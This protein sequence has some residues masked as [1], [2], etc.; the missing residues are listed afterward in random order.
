MRVVHRERLCSKAYGASVSGTHT[1]IIVALPREAAALVS[2]WQAHKQHHH[3]GIYMWTRA[4]AIVVAAGMGAARAAFAV[5]AALAHGAVSSLISA[6]LAGA[7]DPAIAVGSVIEAT[8]VIDARSGERHTTASC[9]PQPVRLVTG[10]GIAGIREKARLF[11]SYDAAACDMEAATVARLAGAHQ[12]PFR[13]IKAVSDNFDFELG[14]MERFTTRHGHFHT[15]RFALHTAVRPH[16]WAKTMKL[17][18]HSALALKR[19]TATLE[20]VLSHPTA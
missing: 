5:E 16:T 4:D 17:G 7:C 13:A 20:A 3:R 15:R 1:A 14:A 18:R 9:Q 19:L 6:G 8:E 10:N 11:A 2:G 12:I